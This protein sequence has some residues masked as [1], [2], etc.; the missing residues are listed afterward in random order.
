MFV[1]NEPKW[2]YSDPWDVGLKERFEGFMKGRRKVAYFYHLPDNSTFRYR[3][4]NPVEVINRLSNDITA[5]WFCLNDQLVFDRVVDAA[6]VIVIC[7]LQYESLVG[8]LM[9]RAQRRGIPVI[10]DVDDLVFDTE[11]VELIMRTLAQDLGRDGP[12]NYWYSYTARIGATLRRCNAAI[13]TNEFLAGQIRSYANIPTRIVPNF[14]C[15]EQE[16][17]SAQILNQKRRS[18]YARDGRIHIGYF[19]GSPSHDA[20]FLIVAGTLLHLLETNPNVVLRLVGHIKPIGG[21]EKFASRIEV[22]RFC[23]FVNLQALIGSTEINLVPLQDNVF[24]N[25]KSELK[26]FEAAVV[27]TITVA[28]PVFTYRKAMQEGV[29]GLL[30]GEHNWQ[31]KI[32]DAISS[33]ED[34]ACRYKKLVEQA[35]A[36][37]EDVY[38]WKRQLTAIERALFPDQI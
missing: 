28:S 6:D 33:L 24:T 13:A 5:G 29:T 17:Y 19:S 16:K 23:D 30:A 36:V 31:D 10:F 22:H 1:F 14:L 21:L 7:R 18:G 8:R 32:D 35:G 20:D 11:F 25:C 3:V 34:D 2:N 12:W 4:H 9:D 15:P 38:R 27:G 37:S 26:F